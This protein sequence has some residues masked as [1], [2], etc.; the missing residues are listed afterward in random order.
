MFDVSDET[1]DILDSEIDDISQMYNPIN[2]NPIIIREHCIKCENPAVSI[3]P[4]CGTLCR[5]HDSIHRH[6]TGH[7]TQE[8]NWQFYVQQTS[9]NE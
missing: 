7:I 8:L 6:E 2:K 3:C 4:N 9:E 5:G 1:I